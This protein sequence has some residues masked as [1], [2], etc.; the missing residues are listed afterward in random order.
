VDIARL[1]LEVD[2]TGVVKATKALDK[3]EDKGAKAEKSTGKLSK[4]FTTLKAAAVAAAGAI[5]IVGIANIVEQSAT[6]SL[7]LDSI[8]SSLTVAAGSAE[9]A[10]VEFDFLRNEAERLGL[11][12]QSSASAYASLA[13]AAKGTNLEGQ[14]TR[15]IFIATTEAMT[16]LGRGA[17]ETE[18]ALTAFEQ[19]ISK[20]NV[21]AE[22]LRGQ[23]GEVLPGAFQIAA[24]SMGVTT[25]ELDKMLRDGEVLASDL[26]P[27]MAA[28]LSGTFS[29]QAESR[30]KGLQAEINRFK[31]AV[32]DLQTSG[33]M[34]SLAD[35]IRDITTLVS[36]PSFQQGFAAFVGGTIR[37]GGFIAERAAAIGNFFY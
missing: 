32:F 21:S 11:E 3:L 2:S 10:A 23:L 33:N 8:N 1:G 37:L 6:A 29:E 26:L 24:R 19:M 4:G 31:T 9:A 22:E 20:G 30:A 12:L 15:D 7:A 36:N 27:R 14:A 18:R 13:A 34:Q 16:A 17:Q 5:A 35:A 28:E 25:Q